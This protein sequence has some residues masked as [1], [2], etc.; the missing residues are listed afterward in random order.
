MTIDEDG[1]NQIKVL[2]SENNK[3][4]VVD[5]KQVFVEKIFFFKAVCV[6]CLCV[7][8]INVPNIEQII[9]LLF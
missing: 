3:G 4:L 9:Q 8:G 7:A 1:L 2:L 6:V 5:L